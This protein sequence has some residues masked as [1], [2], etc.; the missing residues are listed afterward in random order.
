MKRALI[1]VPEE[2]RIDDRATAGYFL[3]RGYKLVALL[4]NWRVVDQYL[5]RGEA[6]VVVF[7]EMRFPAP[8]E[9]TQDLSRLNR[10]FGDDSVTQ[11]IAG[12]RCWNAE[13]LSQVLD[14]D[15]EIP[16]GLDAEVIS[17]ARRIARALNERH[18]S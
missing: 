11:R 5:A 2:Q 15:G 7:G 12:G 8:G 10:P 17:A 16:R 6:S 9:T 1:F 14:S 13:R 3:R 4:R 18:A